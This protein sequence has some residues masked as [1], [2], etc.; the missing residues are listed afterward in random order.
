MNARLLI[1][2]GVVAL[3]GC[4]SPTVPTVSSEGQPR[5][6]VSCGGVLESW[7]MCYEKAD[8]ACMSRGYEVI[9]SSLEKPIRTGPEATTREL[10]IACRR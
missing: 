5:V 6:I 9:Q 3:T 10:L 7:E 8:L 2:F 4:T 1:L